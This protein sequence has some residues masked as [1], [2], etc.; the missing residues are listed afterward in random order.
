MSA[1]PNWDEVSQWAHEK[2]QSTREENDSVV[3]SFEETLILRGRID[4]LKELLDL[5]RTE[6][7]ILSTEL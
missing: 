2:I 5:A 6:K 4:A 3:L 7:A 1:K